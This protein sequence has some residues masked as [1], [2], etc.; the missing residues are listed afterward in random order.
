MVARQGHVDGSATEHK[1]YFFCRGDQIIREASPAL[2]VCGKKLLLYASLLGDGSVISI[3]RD[4]VICRYS[5]FSF[6]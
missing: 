2:I 4:K 6:W 3:L 1:I 5:G